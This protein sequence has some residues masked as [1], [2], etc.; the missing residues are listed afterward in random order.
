MEKEELEK[1]FVQIDCENIAVF[2]RTLAGFW[3][4]QLSGE[5]KEDI[6]VGIIKS[7]LN[8]YPNLKKKLND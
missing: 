3:D 6:F 7:L 1:H 5:E 4:K 8:K 2:K